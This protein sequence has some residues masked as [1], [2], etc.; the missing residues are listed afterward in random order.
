[1]V[2]NGFYH[3]KDEKLVGQGSIWGRFRVD[4]R[5]NWGH[6]RGVSTLSSTSCRNIEQKLCQPQRRNAV[7]EYEPN[8]NAVSYFIHTNLWYEPCG[9]SQLFFSIYLV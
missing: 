5:L 3:G 6:S 4:L 7:S 8:M 9:G 2:Y 1:M